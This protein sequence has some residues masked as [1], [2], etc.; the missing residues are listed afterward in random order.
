MKRLIWRLTMTFWALFVVVVCA[1]CV[2]FYLNYEKSYSQKLLEI[3]RNLNTIGEEINDTLTKYTNLTLSVGSVIEGFYESSYQVYQTLPDYQIN[4]ILQEIEESNTKILTDDNVLRL[5]YLQTF[6]QLDIILSD[7]QEMYMEQYNLCDFELVP[8]SNSYQLEDELKT[9]DYIDK[10]ELTNGVTILEID[11][12]NQR[13]GRTYKEIHYKGNPIGYIMLEYLAHYVDIPLI[14]T[15]DNIIYYIGNNVY[16]QSDSADLEM[17]EELSTDNIELVIRELTN[18]G[19]YVSRFSPADEIVKMVHFYSTAELQ[20]MVLSQTISL[21][22]F[23]TILLIISF[24]FVSYLLFIVIIRP[25]YLL[26]DYVRRCGEGDYT[27]PPGINSSWRFSFVRIRNAYLENE[28][29]LAVKDNQ[30]QELEYAWKKALVANQAKTHFLAKVSHELKTPLNAIKGY[31][32]LLKLSIDNPKQ[33][34]QI[35]IIDHSSDLLLKQVDELLDFSV[36]EDGKVKLEIDTIDLFHTAHVIEELF[37]INTSKKSL[38]YV[39]NIDE[40]IPSVL[41]GDEARIKQIIINLMSNALKFT[42]HGKIEVSF[43]LD[44]QTENEVY[45]SIRVKDTGKGIAENKLNSIFDSF[46]QENNSIS[47]QFGGTG[48]GL[49]ISKRLAEVMG[50]NL[51][52]ESKVNVGSTFTLFLPLSKIPIIIED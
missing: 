10:I 33:L 11:K 29:L 21:F 38:D 9:I 12:D 8:Y 3:D 15:M 17:V 31:I 13:L 42:E 32:Q 18:K 2:N 25:G 48:L 23:S 34:R 51:I 37:I 47:R 19:Y 14:S 49:S 6:K 28:R 5:A 52:V 30:S 44:Y 26:V 45:L 22:E 24:L 4:M 20:E 41:Y 36:I 50:G 43:D 1:F 7:L 16:I 35:E 46:T 39:V 40:Q 27:I